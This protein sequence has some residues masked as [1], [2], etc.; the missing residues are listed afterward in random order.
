MN[1]LFNTTTANFLGPLH[2][3]KLNFS[4]GMQFDL[5]AFALQNYTS[6]SNLAHSNADDDGKAQIIH[7]RALVKMII[8]YLIDC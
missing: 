2:F 7:D 8:L 3:R 5:V 6:S 1:G 4:F